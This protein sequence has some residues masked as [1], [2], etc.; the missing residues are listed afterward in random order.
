MELTIDIN[1]RIEWL[2]KR[3]NMSELDEEYIKFQMQELAVETVKA[4]AQKEK[5]TIINKADE[6]VVEIK[7]KKDETNPRWCTER[8]IC[9]CQTCYSGTEPICHYDNRYNHKLI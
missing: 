1:K 3:I 5:L 4:V 6:P 7:E 2:K 9:Q 8:L